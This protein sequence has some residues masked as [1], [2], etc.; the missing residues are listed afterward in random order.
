MVKEWLVTI[1]MSKPVS[2]Y[3]RQIIV[4]NCSI[5]GKAATKE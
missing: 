2:S 3:F 1:H 4:N 5:Y